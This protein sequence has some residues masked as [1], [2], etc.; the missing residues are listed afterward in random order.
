MKNKLLVA[1][2]ALW[3]F[4]PLAANADFITDTTYFH[5]EGTNSPGDYVAHGCGSVNFLAGGLACSLSPDYVTWDHVFDLTG[6]GP[7][8]SATLQIWFS[9]DGRGLNELV[10]DIAFG[11]AEDGGWEIG[12]IPNGATSPYDVGIASLADGQ[13]RVTVASIAGDFYIDKS[14]LTIAYAAVPEPATLALL[15][16]GLLGAGFARRRKT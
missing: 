5:S 10:G 13:F 9:D 8:V 16:L 12:Q 11:Y 15:G 1:A 4:S 7:V 14:V 6:L 2:V 3:T